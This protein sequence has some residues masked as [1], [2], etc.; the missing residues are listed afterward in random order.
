MTIPEERTR[1]VLKT[2]QLL[3]DLA[4]PARTPNVPDS[5]RLRLDKQVL[6][7]IPCLWSGTAQPRPRKIKRPLPEVVQ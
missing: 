3:A 7:C 4:N 2:R 1:A 6:P 5:S